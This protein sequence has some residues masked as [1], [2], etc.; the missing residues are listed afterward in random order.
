LEGRTMN[1]FD[2]Q[3]KFIRNYL[4]SYGHK[5]QPVDIEDIFQRSVLRA[6]ENGTDHN[7]SNFY[8][9][10]ANTCLSFLR[11]DLPKMRHEQIDK[12]T[13]QKND[14]SLHILA[15][16]DE[17]DK[18]RPFIDELNDYQRES[19]LMEFWGIE[20]QQAADLSGKS[21][22]SVYIGRCRAVQRLRDMVSKSAQGC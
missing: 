22:N 20:P 5:S 17:M 15:I 16:R 12:N 3:Y 19:I 6:L 11:D 18:L 4:W 2:T 1:P 13:F 8:G 7:G 14:N 10:L 9:Y 21:L